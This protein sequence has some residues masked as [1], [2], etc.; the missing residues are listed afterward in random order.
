MMSCAEGRAAAPYSGPITLIVIRHAQV[1]QHQIGRLIKEAHL[2]IEPHL[3]QS[4][5]LLAGMGYLHAQ[6]VVFQ[7]GREV[8]ANGRL[9]I[10]D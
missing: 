8:I 1:A 10:D 6:I 5:G 2:H 4:Q 3:H 7:E 9:V